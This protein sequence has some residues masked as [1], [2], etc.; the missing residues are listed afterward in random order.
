[1][2]ER[3]IGLCKEN[4]TNL[5][6]LEIALGFS[7]GIIKSWEKKEPSATRLYA[8]ADHFGVS[9]EYLLTGKEKDSPEETAPGLSEDETILLELFRSLP[10]EEHRTALTIIKALVSRP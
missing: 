4:N 10:A 7:N 2:V 5:R 6:Q 9:V 1:M 3:I 8:V